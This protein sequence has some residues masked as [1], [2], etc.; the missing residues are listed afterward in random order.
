MA[1]VDIGVEVRGDFGVFGRFVAKTS[2]ESRNHKHPTTA[3][4]TN[5]ARTE[6]RKA[7]ASK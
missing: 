5:G 2:A 6:T 3:M 1:S 4:V 7:R